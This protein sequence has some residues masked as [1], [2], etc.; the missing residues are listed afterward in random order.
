MGKQDMHTE[1]WWGNPLEGDYLE[2]QI[3]DREYNI[4]KDFRAVKVKLS[5]YMP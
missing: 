2:F 5:H 3:G 4:K 1:F